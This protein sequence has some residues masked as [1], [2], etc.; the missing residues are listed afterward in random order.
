MVKKKKPV[1]FLDDGIESKKSVHLLENE[2]IDYVSYHIKKFEESC[3]G[4]VPTTVTPSI[5]APDGVFKG[6]EGVQ[7]YVSYRKSDDY[8][9]ESPTAYW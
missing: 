5:F 2:N 8:D 4:E 3:C 6:Y 9:D 1:L 7:Q